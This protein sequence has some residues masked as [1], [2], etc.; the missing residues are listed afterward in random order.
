MAD[1][2]DPGVGVEVVLA[3]D[4]PPL[5]VAHE[6][7]EVGEPPAGGVDGGLHPVRT[8]GDAPVQEHRD[9]Q[10]GEAGAEQ[11][12]GQRQTDQ[13]EQ[14]HRFTPV[15]SSRIDGNGIAAGRVGRG[16]PEPPPGC[17]A[18]PAGLGSRY[19]PAVGRGTREG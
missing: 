2:V 15:T 12:R 17:R 14:A 16:P 11:A 5:P 4:P 7:R 19:A 18:A 10:S 6:D 13:G 1:L 8:V 3:V 9:R